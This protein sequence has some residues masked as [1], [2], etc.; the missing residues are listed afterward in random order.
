[1][2]T[3][4]EFAYYTGFPSQKEVDTLHDKITP[5]MSDDIEDSIEKVLNIIES[6][7]K[8]DPKIF[9]VPSVVCFVQ[10]GNP[11]NQFIFQLI[12]VK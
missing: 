8:V 10:D 4:K 3:F 12:S 9:I 5:V 11:V 2:T 1:M 6:F 7:N